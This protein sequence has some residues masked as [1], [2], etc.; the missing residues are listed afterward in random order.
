M[1]FVIRD[2]FTETDK[3]PG[4]SWIP[5][6]SFTYRPALHDRVI[7]YREAVRNA[8]AKTIV[9]E[10]IKFLKEHLVSWEILG[11]QGG[12]PLPTT[13]DNSYKGIPEPVITFMWSCVS[14]YGPDRWKETAKN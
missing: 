1:P 8:T 6:F 3:F 2:G 12:T 5:P 11:E 4:Q 10:Q 7:E 13:D 9:A 14:S